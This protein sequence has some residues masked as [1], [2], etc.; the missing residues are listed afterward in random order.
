MSKI[1]EKAFDASKKIIR[2]IFN[3]SPN[4]ITTSDL[5]RQFEALKHQADRLDEKTGF[6]IEGGNLGFKL[7]GSTLEVNLIYDTMEYKGCVFNPDQETTV[8]TNFT[9]S[10]PY[11]YF[12]LVADKETLTYDTDVTH[13]I[14]GAKFADGTSMR[15]ADQ[16]VYKNER[17]ALTHS[18]GSLNNLV[19]IIAFFRLING[20]VYASENWTSFFSPLRVKDGSGSVGY[21]FETSQKYPIKL[22][23]TYDVAFGKLQGFL[24]DA[25]VYNGCWLYTHSSLEEVDK[26][27][28]E[29]HKKKSPAYL[30]KDGSVFKVY[31]DGLS[32]KSISTLTLEEMA[33]NIKSFLID[34]ITRDCEGCIIFDNI[35]NTYNVGKL[36]GASVTFASPITITSKSTDSPSV[37][38]ITGA[39]VGVEHFDRAGDTGLS[40]IIGETFGAN[41][42]SKGFGLNYN[43]YQAID[44]DKISV[45]ISSSEG[46]TVALTFAN[47]DYFQ[48]LL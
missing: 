45:D 1:L 40:S 35:P 24:G 30:I 46:I 8:E 13:E 10:A 32:R 6:L 38:T 7:E 39:H 19:G 20:K 43:D 22:G 31:L 18:V 17:F 12:C 42:S 44:Y 34:I 15:A 3:G 21:A 33:S 25:K 48:N 41:F 11:A 9:A 28:Y 14:A 23:D 36:I 29:Y 16:I 27:T 4:L 47:K 26:E 37:K 5:N 2:S